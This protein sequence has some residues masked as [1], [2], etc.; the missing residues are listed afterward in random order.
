MPNMDGP[1]PLQEIRKSEAL[2]QLPVLI[3]T[4]EKRRE[5][6]FAAIRAGTNG[7]ILKP[8]SEA[9]LPDKSAQIAPLSA[10]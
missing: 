10:S 6:V 1:T 2:A 3:V 9:A 7:Y 8:C 4:A 5:H